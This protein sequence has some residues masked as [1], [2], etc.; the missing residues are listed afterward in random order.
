MN[1]LNK[2][3]GIPLRDNRAQTHGT[4][5]IEG[6][7]GKRLQLTF[8]FSL[9]LLRNKIYTSRNS[10]NK[11]QVSENHAMH[12]FRSALQHYFPETTKLLTFRKMRP[13]RA[14]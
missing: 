3:K 1:P 14:L 9:L 8:E 10:G 6:V 11:Q 7:S 4:T 13:M 12:G 2:S 5:T